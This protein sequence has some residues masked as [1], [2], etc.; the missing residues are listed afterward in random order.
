MDEAALKSKLRD[1][2]KEMLHGAVIWGHNDS[3]AGL[4]D[5]SW[6]WNGFTTWVEAKYANPSFKTRGIQELTCLRLEQASKCIYVIFE[7]A[8]KKSTTKH[9]RIV[10]PKSIGKWRTDVL[11]YAVGFDYAAV[12]DFI[13]RSHSH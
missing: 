12:V 7:E 8:S 3:Q 5:S 4:P 10:S 11:L 6:N 2:G 9:T 1:T 13:R